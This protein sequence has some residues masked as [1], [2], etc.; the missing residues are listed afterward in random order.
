MSGSTEKLAPNPARQQDVAVV[1]GILA[2][3]ENLLMV[4]EMPEFMTERLKH[5]FV[6]V[7]LL[8]DSGS[9]HDLRQAINDLNHRLRYVDGTYDQ[10]ISPIPVPD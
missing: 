10:P 2:E 9:P 1:I 6:K 3:L 8:N 4:D 7:H 5:R